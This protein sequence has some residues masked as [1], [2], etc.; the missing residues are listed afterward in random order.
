[1][2]KTVTDF[3]L[4]T[5]ANAVGSAVV[6]VAFTLILQ[7][8]I[9]RRDDTQRIRS[10]RRIEIEFLTHKLQASHDTGPSLEVYHD[11]ERLYFLLSLDEELKKSPGNA[12][13]VKRWRELARAFPKHE[14]AVSDGER[15][16]EIERM[17]SEVTWDS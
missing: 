11:L 1:M 7:R 9:E 6:A 4:N 16:R 3:L 8:W 5:A 14:G 10:E 2:S 13:F 12:R 17:L 15:T